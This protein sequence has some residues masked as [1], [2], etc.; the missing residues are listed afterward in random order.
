VR[1][2]ELAAVEPQLIIC[3]V[4]VEE[5]KKELTRE[6]MLMTQEV[7]R[8]HKERQGLEQHIADLFAFYAKQ[9]GSGDVS[10]YI[11]YDIYEILTFHDRGKKASKP[12]KG[13]H[14]HRILRLLRMFIMVFRVFQDSWAPQQV[15]C[16]CAGRF[17]YIDSTITIQ[18]CQSINQL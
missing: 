2:S 9:K 3:T 5:F 10:C 7:D 6:V 17:G 4:H 1:Q 16:S 13:S 18:N 11:L 12:R 8:L 15:V 14:L